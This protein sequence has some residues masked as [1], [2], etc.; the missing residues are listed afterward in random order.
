MSPHEKLLA[1]YIEC[2]QERDWGK[3]HSPK[4]LVLDLASEVG[5]LCD[6]FR[7]MTE[8]ESRHPSSEAMKEIRKE[9]ADVFKA[10][11]YLAHELNI[12]PIEA[13]YE[14]LAELKS[15]YPAD[16]CRGSSSKYTVYLSEK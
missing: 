8:E 4:N 11:L 9:V 13:S 14:K 2:Y 5:E 15:K 10:I 7:W 6:L 16:R 1:A 12:D 3:F